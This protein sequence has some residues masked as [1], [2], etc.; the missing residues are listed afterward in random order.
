VQDSAAAYA[1]TV[2]RIDGWRRRLRKKNT[3]PGET[4]KG[5]PRSSYDRA[6]GLLARREH[7]VRELRTKLA[8]RGHGGADANA[9]LDRLR[10]QDHQSDERF[11]SSLARRRAAQGYGPRRIGAELKSHGLGDAGVREIIAGIDIDWSATAA[12][13]L[14]RRFGATVPADRIERGKRAAFLLR[15]GFDPATVRAVTRAETDDPVPDFD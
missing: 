8:A 4:A 15:R 11:A 13:Q 3:T 14:R 2:A 6:L 7:S 5:V 10:Q 9:A 12:T 1:R